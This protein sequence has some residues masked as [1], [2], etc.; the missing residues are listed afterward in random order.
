MTDHK[1]DNTASDDPNGESLEQQPQE[2][3][4]L[5]DHLQGILDQIE[6]AEPGLL[7]AE[8][9]IG[10]DGKPRF[11]PKPK[12]KPKPEPKPQ[13]A[14]AAAPEPAAKTSD[15]IEEDDLAALIN[16]AIDQ[17]SQAG[18][19]SKAPASKP[20]AAPVASDAELSRAVDRD[21]DQAVKQ[22][23]AV[24]PAKPAKP[25]QS[26]KV[27]KLAK[28]DPASN[29]V[30]IEPEELGQAIEDA[31]NNPPP[32]NDSVVSAPEEPTTA[33]PPVAATVSVPNPA[34]FDPASN[35]VPI[36]PEEL[37]DAIEEAFNNP[38]PVNDTVEDQP[39]IAPPEPVVSVEAPAAAE[40]PANAVADMPDDAK[41]N[42][43][44]L[45]AL[46]DAMGDVANTKADVAAPPKAAAT[47]PPAAAA[48][49]AASVADMPDDAKLNNDDLDALFDAMGEVANTKSDVAAP[50]KATPTPPPAAATP[51]AASVADM[52]DDAKLNND[53]LDALFDAM[54]EVAN[55]K[56]DVAA[57]PQAA[58]TTP[59]AA[60]APAAASVADMPDDA[61]L[62]NDDL[63]ALF[64]AMG[65]VANTK[66][67][68]AAPPKSQDITAQSTEKP[69]AKSLADV[70][71]FERMS[72]DDLDALF[73]DP[74]AMLAEHEQSQPQS[75]EPAEA[76]SAFGEDDFMSQ[77]DNVLNQAQDK[78]A[79]IAVEKQAKQAKRQAQRLAQLKEKAADNPEIDQL[80][81]EN[82]SSVFDDQAFTQEWDMVLNQAREQLNEVVGK[83]KPAASVDSGSGGKLSNDD[84]T[85]QLDDLLA[86]VQSESE[87]ES[88]FESL[89]QEQLTGALD[90]VLGQAMQQLAILTS[91][92]IK[93]KAEQQQ[94]KIQTIRESLSND[95]LAD[96]LDA[97]IGKALDAHEVEQA[98]ADQAAEVL[99]ADAFAA[100]W[101]NVLDD[102]KTELQRLAEEKKKRKEKLQQQIEAQPKTESEPSAKPVTT[103]SHNQDMGSSIDLASELDDLFASATDAPDKSQAT[104]QTPPADDAHQTLSNDDLA[105]EL[106]SLLGSAVENETAAPA[107]VDE[108]ALDTSIVSESDIQDLLDAQEAQQPA[109]EVADTVDAAS[110]DDQSAKAHD[111]AADEPQDP[112]A[113][114]T[115]IDSLLAEHASDA[116]SDMFETPEAIAE[117]GMNEEDL[118]A[119][120]QSPE[121]VLENLQE[122]S[123]AVT[124]QQAAPQQPEPAPTPQQP[125]VVEQTAP[126]SE[127]PAEA[128]ANVQEALDPEDLE[129]YFE[130]PNELDQV[131][132]QAAQAPPPQASEAEEVYEAVEVAADADEEIMGD[133][134]SPDETFDEDVSQAEEIGDDAFESVEDI[135][136]QQVQHASAKSESLATAV[137]DAQEEQGDETPPVVKGP[138]LLSR[139]ISKVKPMGRAA[140]SLVGKLAKQAKHMGPVINKGCAMINSP[141]LRFASPT[142]NLV[143]Y[144]GL[145][146][147][148]LGVIL[149][150]VFFKK[151]LFGM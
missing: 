64:D 68:V 16:Q 82:N 133:F 52:P 83:K 140:G 91:E 44:D 109:A 37:G 59:P 11:V 145:V 36:E 14:V 41:L 43:D 50:P 80:L 39:T 144:I 135:E 134:V 94:E 76:Q 100:D 26:V 108:S 55:T 132:A 111:P 71:D 29:F 79:E 99:D 85:N 131:P 65:E 28:F 119:A 123:K 72:N 21:I 60:D 128:D 150:C 151:M 139:L 66:A 47:A 88:K 110:S 105:A 25:V 62:N 34:T 115:H 33:T 77:W 130:S 129:G 51:A 69:A 74:A 107:P 113:M 22:A 23:S 63:D 45:D 35:F 116:V 53:D 24:K 104:A 96:E 6:D 49:A 143:G 4:S 73:E 118:E 98:K 112:A 58:A 78:L 46:F 117:N 102:A 27:P 127:V 149:F 12:P 136:Q 1:P 121:Q 142:R 90:D 125:E 101:A 61:K 32:V 7:E 18:D 84:L 42:N 9:L 120:F 70:D 148:F 124:E 81:E 31:F 114:I 10:D 95:E 103:P 146:Q 138:G 67:D 38:P 106:E 15:P 137:T 126:I 87:S 93:R 54:G 75:T 48:P 5:E 13:P 89:D 147:L 56:A 86:E 122:A 3:L 92:K 8:Q 20:T 19:D 2:E 17:A 57:P 97:L 141:L 30:P 40:S